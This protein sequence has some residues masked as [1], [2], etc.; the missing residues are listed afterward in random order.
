[1]KNNLLQIFPILQDIAKKMNFNIWDK[2]GVLSLGSIISF[3]IFEK[4]IMFLIAVLIGVPTAF[5]KI[6]EVV[7]ILREKKKDEK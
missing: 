3:E 6:R 7:L 4:W 2:M 5:M 1:M